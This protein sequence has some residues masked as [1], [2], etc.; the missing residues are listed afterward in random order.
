MSS[1]HEADPFADLDTDPRSSAIV[2][3]YR[4]REGLID[5][6]VERRKLLR[7]SQAEVASRMGVGQSTISEF[8]NEA[9]D[10]RLSTL[11]RYA[12]ALDAHVSVS[13]QAADTQ[14]HQWRMTATALL[15]GANLTV[16]HAGGGVSVP[17]QLPPRGYVQPRVRPATQDV[18]SLERV[19]A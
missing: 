10:P 6:L 14:T 4:A 16:V 15:K 18:E 19:G 2:D 12:R 1:H 8:E 11:Q 3:D 13:L 9:T 17:R 7:V 5:E